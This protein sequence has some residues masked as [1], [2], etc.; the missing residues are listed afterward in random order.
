MIAFD[1]KPQNR[2]SQK[3]TD[4]WLS[5]DSHPVA[6]SSPENA[7]PGAGG[8]SLG[9]EKSPAPSLGNVADS[10]GSKAQDSGAGPH[11]S[12]KISSAKGV[13][14][15]LV[16]YARGLIDPPLSALK[17]AT[18]PTTAGYE[19][20]ARIEKLQVIDSDSPQSVTVDCTMSQMVNKISQGSKQPSLF[21]IGGSISAQAT[22]DSRQKN[23][24]EKAKKEAVEAVATGIVESATEIL[25][26]Q[27]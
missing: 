15:S 13:D 16:E 10:P 9:A 12:S 1:K 7:H 11:V 5:T 23:P 24:T 6:S 20:S 3:K 21:G 8:A 26:R 18:D 22:E 14:P 2:D 25:S 4:P 17:L 19:V 27:K